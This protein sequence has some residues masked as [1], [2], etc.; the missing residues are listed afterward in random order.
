[1]D[2]GTLD[3]W[4]HMIQELIEKG[5]CTDTPTFER[6][7]RSTQRRSKYD[8]YSQPSAFSVCLIIVTEQE[9]PTFFI[10]RPGNTTFFSSRLKA[11][12][13]QTKGHCS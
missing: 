4:A 3:A 12:P 8:Q 10:L 6:R 9:A 11:G 1:M 2:V 5:I 7:V 13:K